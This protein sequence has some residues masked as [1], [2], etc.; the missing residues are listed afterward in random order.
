MVLIHS[1]IELNSNRS[2]VEFPALRKQRIRGFHE[3]C[4]MIYLSIK[5]IEELVLS[6]ELVMVGVD[7]LEL[8]PESGDPIDFVSSKLCHY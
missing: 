5:I 2:I 3:Y 1:L 4:I 7:F 6:D 8:V